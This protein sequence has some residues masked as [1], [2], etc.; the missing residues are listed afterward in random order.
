MRPVYE[1]LASEGT[2]DLA[3]FW[4]ACLPV[5][6]GPVR[7][8]AGELQEEFAALWRRILAVPAGTRR[9]EVRSADIEGSW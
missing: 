6:H 8:T 5:L 2:V 9:V 7:A 1:R 4:F 3:A